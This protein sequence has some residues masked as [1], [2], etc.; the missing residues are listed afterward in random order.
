MVV[1]VDWPAVERVSFVPFVLASATGQS[2]RAI[3]VADGWTLQ[4]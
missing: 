3:V 1:I 4:D 2:R